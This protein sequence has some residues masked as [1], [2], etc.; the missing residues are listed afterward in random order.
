MVKKLWPFTELPETED[1]AGQALLGG[2]AFPECQQP[3]S[4]ELPETCPQDCSASR[5]LL[6]RQ[7]CASVC[8]SVSL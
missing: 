7:H 6:R 4:W 2:T 8:V 1:R 5:V 3:K